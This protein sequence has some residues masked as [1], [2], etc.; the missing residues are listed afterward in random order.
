MN[1]KIY[2][3]A[4]AFLLSFSLKAQI[5]YSFSATTGTYTAIKGTAITPAQL[6]TGT[7]ASPA[8]DDGYKNAIPIGFSFNYN[9]TSYTTIN[10]CTNGF[11]ALG[12]PFAPTAST[13][14]PIYNSQHD[15]SGTLGSS[16][17]L[18]RPIIAP[19]WADLDVQTA[20]AG[21]GMTYKLTGTAPNR[22]FTLQWTSVKW[23]FGATAGCMGIQLKLYETTNV[24]QFL[25][26][27]QTGAIKVSDTTRTQNEAA[28]G[29]TA[30]GYG[31]SNFISVQ[32]TSTNPKVSKFTEA[33][34]T[35]RPSDNQIYTFT[36]AVAPK[37]DAGIINIYTVATT[38]TIADGQN[39]SAAVTNNGTSAL[40]NVAVTL[41]VSGANSFTDVQTIPSLGPDSS[42]FVTFNSFIPTNT[43]VNNIAVSLASDDDTSNNYL[44]ISQ[45]VTLSTIDYTAGGATGG[46]GQSTQTIDLGALF[47]NPNSH[48]INNILL[49]FVKN[50]NGVQPVTVSIYDATGKDANGNTPAPG[51]QIWTIDTTSND[52]AMSIPISPSVNVSGDYFVVVSQTDGTIP[53]DYAYETESPLR[54]GQFYFQTSG[55]AAWVDFAS[56]TIPF[57]HLD[58]GVQYDTSTLPVSFAKLS[59]LAQSN[60]TNLINW[61][62]TNEMN[63]TGF[64]LQRSAN[65]TSFSD[66]AF[67]PTKSVASH[68][69]TLTYQF[70]DTKPLNG[71]NYYRLKQ[72]DVN[73]K[74]TYSTV[75]C[76]KQV[77]TTLELAGL[78]PNP[79]TSQ[80]NIKVNSPVATNASVIIN[81]MAGRTVARYPI[82][83]SEGSNNFTF[84]VNSLPKGTYLVNFI[85]DNGVSKATKFE[86]N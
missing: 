45:N 51:G 84:Q 19:F 3:F 73:G 28:I 40:T 27:R 75:I 78:Y 77:Q 47:S 68:H 4:F 8:T 82:Q 24:I 18:Y 12:T 64:E 43:G 60:K 5:Y 34:L 46:I 83:V 61:V 42:I 38:A 50:P 53:L 23:D 7:L 16:D 32:D 55:T 79:V 21:G 62:T 52:G 2:L 13:T 71:L 86:K 59:G 63:N 30:S 20:A 85:S 54:L 66:V 49:H 70:T 39:I 26:K 22:V 80:M 67:I 31:I 11:A 29:L 76:I 69:T 72:V 10:A 36:P 17:T 44:S 9:G 14:N 1:R 81:D 41:T 6:T 57:V 56:S 65:G 25:Y 15:L 33:V 74:F 58:I 37:N 35:G 48:K